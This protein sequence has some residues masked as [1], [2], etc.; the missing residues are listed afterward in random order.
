MYFMNRR[1]ADSNVCV[2]SV[3]PGL[4]DTEVTRGFQDISWM[5]WGWKIAK[6]NLPFT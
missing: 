4:V 6:G 1:L 5:T 3:H 2:L